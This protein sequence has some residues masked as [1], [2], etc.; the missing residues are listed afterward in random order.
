MKFKL[1]FLSTFLISIITCS[2]QI[3]PCLPNFLNGKL[4]RTFPYSFTVEDTVST[5][6]TYNG[7]PVYRYGNEY[8]LRPIKNGHFKIF[9]TEGGD[10]TVI[11]SKQINVENPPTSVRLRQTENGQTISKQ[12]LSNANVVVNIFNN[13]LSLYIPIIEMKISYQKKNK[14]IQSTIKG[15]F[16]P[17]A[18]GED[19][20]KAES[21]F[22][23]LD[24]IVNLVDEFQMRVPSAIFY[25][26]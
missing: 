26:E 25:L 7:A 5:F 6:V 12:T 8:V 16:I 3:T 24:I 20:A 2:G 19:I 10:T 11:M 13:E 14:R 21:P 4:L 18:I 9:K 22:L 17:K 23:V 1:F 15:G